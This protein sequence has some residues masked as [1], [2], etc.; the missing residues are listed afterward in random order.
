MPVTK[1]DVAY[2][3]KL[4]RLAFSDDEMEKFTAQLNTILHHMEKLNEIDTSNVEP[5]SHVSDLKNVLR[6]DVVTPSLPR[7]EVL[8]NAPSKNE[9]FFKV[10]KVIES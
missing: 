3:A 7:D 2:V 1:H 10:P 5:L 9:K 4:A 8:K 6:E